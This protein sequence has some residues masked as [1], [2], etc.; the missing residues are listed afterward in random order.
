MTIEQAK[1]ILMARHPIDQNKAFDMLREHSQRTDRKLIEVA[2]AV[3][4]SH[5]L[6]LP[7]LAGTGKADGSS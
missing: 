2:E 5:V 6:L 1:G 3:V 7:P 4:Q